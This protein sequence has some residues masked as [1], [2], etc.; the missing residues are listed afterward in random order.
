MFVS[1]CGGVHLEELGTPELAAYDSALYARPWL[2][3][4]WVK[5]R[6]RCRM[7]LKDT[8]INLRF[9]TDSL[10]SC[11]QDRVEGWG[12]SVA[13]TR[14]SIS[15]HDAFVP[16]YSPPI[17]SLHN[18]IFSSLLSGLTSLLSRRKL[19]FFPAPANTVHNVLWWTSFHCNSYLPGHLELFY[20][21]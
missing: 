1:V 16:D 6:L 18:G 3:L 17:L 9:S 8:V 7:A 13:L 11:Y 21:L 4:P 14:L 20:L 19:V 2:V 5:H 15:L 12:V 10:L